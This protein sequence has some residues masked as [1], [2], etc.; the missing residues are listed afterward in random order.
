MDGSDEGQTK[1]FPWIAQ[2][3]L[4]PRYSKK[5]QWVLGRPWLPLRLDSR[6]VLSL[7][8]LT[9]RLVGAASAISIPLAPST[10]RI[11]LIT[12]VLPTPGPPVVTRTFEGRASRSAAR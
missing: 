2:L 8:R 11:E 7:S 9:A 6:P 12:V 3:S 1:A 4:Q 10:L 5:E